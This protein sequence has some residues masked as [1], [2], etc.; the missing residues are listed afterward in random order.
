MLRGM[1]LIR[2]I[3]IQRPRI[4]AGAGWRLTGAY[5][6]DRG[7]D[8]SWAVDLRSGAHGLAQAGSGGARPAARPTRRRSDGERR[9]NS[10]TELG[11]TVCCGGC[12]GTSSTC[13]RTQQ[14]VS[15]VAVTTRSSARQT[16]AAAALR[17][18]RA[19]GSEHK[20]LNK[21]H[22]W[23]PYLA[24]MLHSDTQESGRRRRRGSTRRRGTG[25]R[26][27]GEPRVWGDG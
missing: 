14:G 22:R 23:A 7:V 11:C 17:R 26:R 12:T 19:S 8:A 27:R 6:F 5:R 13:V 18:S 20:R 16:A 24:A 3:K 15:E 25:R 9:R 2:R 4:N 21:R 10:N 1:D